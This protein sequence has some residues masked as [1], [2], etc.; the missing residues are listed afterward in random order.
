MKPKELTKILRNAQSAYGD[1]GVTLEF[2]KSK[3]KLLIDVIEQH[4]EK[5]VWHN[6]Y[7]DAVVNLMLEV[8]KMKTAAQ[9]QE[10]EKENN[11]VSLQLIT[12]GKEPP[13]PIWLEN[14]EEGNMFWVQSVQDNHPGSY[15]S[16]LFRLIKK[17]GKVYVLRTV[18]MNT[19]V[20]QDVP[21]IPIRFSKVFSKVSNF[22]PEEKQDEQRDRVVEGAGSAD[23]AQEVAGPKGVP[24]FL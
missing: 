12:G 16:T 2:V 3:L 11:V 4:G 13:S 14:E 17:M 5:I 8:H 6:D 19:Q 10:E 9:T 7:V 20:S 18:D 21:V 22:I 23:Q 1:P 24:E 15:V